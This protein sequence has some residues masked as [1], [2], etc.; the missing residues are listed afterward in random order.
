MKDNAWYFRGWFVY[1]F[2]HLIGAIVMSGC[3]WYF[4]TSLTIDFLN[5]VPYLLQ[6]FLNTSYFV[7]GVLFY[8]L[9]AIVI[10]TTLTAVRD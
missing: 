10:N 2:I 6:D 3:I 8:L 4:L 1:G 9:L 7:I 5:S